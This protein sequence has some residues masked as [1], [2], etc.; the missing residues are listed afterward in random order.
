MPPIKG[1]VKFTL[2]M[3]VDSAGQW[4]ARCIHLPP[5]AACPLGSTCADGHETMSPE[6]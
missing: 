4:G 3:L 2:S 1:V 6:I 5:P